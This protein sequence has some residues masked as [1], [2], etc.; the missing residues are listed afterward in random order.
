VN[1]TA[2]DPP[3]AADALAC[4][5]LWMS[6]AEMCEVRVRGRPVRLSLVRL[7]MLAALL[8]AGGRVLSR[9]DLYREV[10]GETLPDGSRAIDVHIARIRKV[11]GPL[12]RMIVTV[13]GMGYRLDIVALSKSG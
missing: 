8:R 10:C 1:I 9:P 5:P 4:G 6:P 12:G 3:A 11:L 7:R 2:E 13:P